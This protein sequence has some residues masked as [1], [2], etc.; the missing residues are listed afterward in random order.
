MSVSLRRLVLSRAVT[1]LAGLAAALSLPAAAEIIL[2]DGA[3]ATTPPS[4][5]YQH[6]TLHSIV[7]VTPETRQMAILPPPPVFIQSPPLL[8]R[9]PYSALPYPPASVPYGLNSS[10]R[11]SNQDMAAYH[12]Q[13]SHA[14]S[15][16][17]YNRSTYLNAGINPNAYWYG[18]YGPYGSYGYVYPYPPPAPRGFNQGAHPSNQD[19]TI[20]NIERAHAFSMDAYRRP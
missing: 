9:S 20:Y 8:W 6:P 18:T 12:L 7:F 3:P 14:F 10:S 13:R 16:D 2:L 17:L 11:P 1:W 19:M 5:V 15:Q 4:Y